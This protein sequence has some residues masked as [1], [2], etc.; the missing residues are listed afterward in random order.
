[1][2]TILRGKPLDT[3]FRASFVEAGEDECWLWRGAIDCDGYGRLHQ[4]SRVIMAHRFAWEL[5]H[6]LSWPSGSIALHACDI[7]AC[8]NPRHIR[9]GTIAENNAD[10]RAKRRHAFGERNGNARLT[11]EKALEIRRRRAAGEKARVLALEFGVSDSLV[12]AVA[13]GRKWAHLGQVSP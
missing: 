6:G 2:K 9:P 1:M 4:G 8:V 11:D 12:C 10:A 7:R 13:A 3:R 5:R